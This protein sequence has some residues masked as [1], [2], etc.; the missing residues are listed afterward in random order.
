[1]SEIIRTNN[2]SKNYGS[3]TALR[4]MNITIKKG[5]IYGLVGNNGAGKTTFLRILTGQSQPTSGT[6]ELFGKSGEKELQRAR[7]RTGAIIEQPCFYPKLT[8]GK[9]LEYYRIQRGIPGKDSVD[10][11]LEAVNILEAKNKKFSD[12]S[13][14]MK[15]RVGLALAMM[16][17]PE[18][19]ILDEPIN[20]L[21]PSGIIEIRNLILKLNKENNVTIIISSHILSELS[22]IATSYGFLNKGV[23]VEQLT[24][25]ELEDKCT[26]YI[27]VKVDNTKK[28]CAVIEE[29]L[30]YKNYKVLPGN[31]IHLFEGIKEPEKVSKLAVE[32][33]M[34]LKEITQ[35]MI[36]L[37]DYYM[38]LVGGNDN[39]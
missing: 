22:N 39:E 11:A 16:G 3:F 6:F 21:D 26:S 24:A 35:K 37:E 8:V 29:K 15:Q 4:D 14:G 2:I 33:G 10:R 38:S 27:E 5:D 17:E 23:L 18:L 20:G 7:R 9:N 19:L 34:A 1:M 32:N 36:K 28:L 31:V 30:G 12:L 13:L 25:K